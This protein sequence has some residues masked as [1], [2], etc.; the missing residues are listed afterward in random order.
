MRFPLRGRRPV[1]CAHTRPGRSRGGQDRIR[2]GALAVA[3]TCGIVL[4]FIV[5]ASAAAADNIKLTGSFSFTDT[6]TCVDPIQVASSYDE[7]MHTFYDNDGN[8]IRLSFTG[9]V[10]ITYTNLNTGATYVPDSSGPATVDL[11]SGQTVLRG[12]NGAFFDPNGVL[13]ATDGRTVLDAN[14][15]L[16]SMVGH[17]KGV[18]DQLGTASAP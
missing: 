9:K 5:A 11:Q 10:D 17:Q 14:G 15:N 18:C 1:G 7:Q 6:T 16:I 3:L 2:I 4:A 8:A 12:G 13:L